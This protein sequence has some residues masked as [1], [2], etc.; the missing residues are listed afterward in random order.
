MTPDLVEGNVVS[1]NVR[2][3]CGGK[4]IAKLSLSNKSTVN[5]GDNVLSE[6]SLSATEVNVTK[7]S[8]V[9]IVVSSKLTTG[10]KEIIAGELKGT[11][12]ITVE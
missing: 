4:G 7:D 1:T 11:E 5:L 8:S 9:D 10:S 3:E 2:L 12:V 6:V